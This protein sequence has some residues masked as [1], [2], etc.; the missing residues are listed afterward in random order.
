MFVPPTKTKTKTD[1][2][3]TKSDKASAKYPF[4]PCKLYDLCGDVSKQWVVE[5]YVFNR[6][7]NKLVR[8]RVIGFNRI[9]TVRAGR[10]AAREQT[11]YFPHSLSSNSYRFILD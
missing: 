10:A 3:M 7:K 2:G 6:D 9:K 5:Y 11:G 1:F 4:Q 8:R